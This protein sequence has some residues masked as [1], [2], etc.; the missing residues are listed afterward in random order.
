MTLDEFRAAIASFR[1]F[2][3]ALEKYRSCLEDD[4]ESLNDRSRTEE[5]KELFVQRYD[6]SVDREQELAEELNE[7]IRRFNRTSP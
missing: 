2:Q 3:S 6:R 1:E 5:K 4:F 7:Q